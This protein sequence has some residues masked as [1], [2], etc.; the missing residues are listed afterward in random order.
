VCR[1]K[2]RHPAVSAQAE[3]AEQGMWPCQGPHLVE[4]P[5]AGCFRRGGAGSGP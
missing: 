3:T 2:R 1:P 4:R 5:D